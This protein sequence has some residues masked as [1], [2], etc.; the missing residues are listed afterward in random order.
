MKLRTI[1]M[2]AVAALALVAGRV[3]AQDAGWD[4]R[5]GI[6]FT[7]PNPFGGG[8][9]ISVINDLNG[10][11]GAQYNLTPDRA[12]RLSANI[13][14]V[15][16]GINEVKYTTYTAKEVPTWTSNY[17]ID[18]GAEYMV[19]LSQAA[20]SP[21]VGA[22]GGIGFLQNN[23][24]GQ[25]ENVVA[26]NTIRKFDDYSR[27]WEVFAG[28]SAGLEWRIHKVISLY[29]EYQATLTLASFTSGQAKTTTNGVVTTSA[30]ESESHYLNLRT[31]IANSGKLGIIAFF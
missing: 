8:S 4:T 29:A 20:V 9:G 1:G 22:G 2:A 3:E 15:S 5:Y 7:L 24:V 27:T 10:S 18:L 14:R 28:G 11:V 23:R 25:E 12:L 6:L 16:A 17:A 26:L 31:G 19:R 30:K 13:M 21:Y